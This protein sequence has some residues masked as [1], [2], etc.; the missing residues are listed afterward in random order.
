MCKCV[1]IHKRVH[2]MHIICCLA[3]IF[4]VHNIE[5]ICVLLFIFDKK[6]VFAVLH[7][8]VYAIIKNFRVTH[9][10]S[11]ASCF[12]FLSI[13]KNIHTTILFI[14]YYLFFGLPFEKSSLSIHQYHS[15]T[16]NTLTPYGCYYPQ[17]VWLYACMDSY[18]MQL[19]QLT[20]NECADRK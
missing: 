20:M 12:L 4:T 9:H 15:V 11:I 6:K 14:H 1:H 18:R 17:F 2:R 16:S 3:N 10:H 8:V 5:Y 13:R 7:H 19:I